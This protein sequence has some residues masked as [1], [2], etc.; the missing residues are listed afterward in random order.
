MP[1]HLF[2]CDMCDK[3]HEFFLFITD[4]FP[5]QCPVCGAGEPSYRRVWHGQAPMGFLKDAEPKTVGQLAERNAR[6]E[7]KERLELMAEERRRK[8]PWTGPR[9]GKT[10]FTTGLR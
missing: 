1:T 7:G 4:P 3:P 9:G 2:H 6:R 5:T 8:K 10:L